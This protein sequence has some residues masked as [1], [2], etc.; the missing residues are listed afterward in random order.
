MSLSYLSVTLAVMSVFIIPGRTS[1]TCT[2]SPAKRTD[3]SCEAMESPALAMQYS[4]RLTE[5]VWTDIEVTKTS[6]Y[7]P[8]NRDSPG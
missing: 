1:N 2:P 3:Q 7:P 5:A 8:G 6:L 4:P